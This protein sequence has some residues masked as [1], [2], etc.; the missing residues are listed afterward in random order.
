MCDPNSSFSTYVEDVR[1]R[2]VK[3]AV[4]G[5]DSDWVPDAYVSKAI[6]AYEEM[7]L[8]EAEKLLKSAKESAK[9]LRKYFEEVDLTEEDDRGKLKWSAKD[10]INN[11]GKLGNVIQGIKDLEE[12]V[13]KEQLEQ[14]EMRGG[15]E[16]T[17]F[18]K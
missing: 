5:E 18:N 2:K 10:L 6:D 13:E 7:N 11:L 1:K 17:E 8:T 14:G 12:Q 9:S 16:L 15:V 3:E 4:F